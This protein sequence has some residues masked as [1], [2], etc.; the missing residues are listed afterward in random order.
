M[1]QLTIEG[2]RIADFT[3]VW[4]GPFATVQL[5]HL[6]AEVIRIETQHRV[7]V[8]RRIPPFADGQAGLNRSGY[9]N[10]YNQGKQS[11]ALEPQAARSVGHCQEARSRE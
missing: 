5:A 10:Q 4:A 1:S 7:C 9:Y 11:M 6:G 3:W 2:V 8:T